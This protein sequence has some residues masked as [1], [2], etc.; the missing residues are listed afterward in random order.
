MTVRGRHDMRDFDMGLAMG[1]KEQRRLCIRKVGKGF[2]ARLGWLNPFQEGVAVAVCFMAA[3]NTEKLP[4]VLTI[5]PNSWREKLQWRH[6][7][8]R[9]C[10]TY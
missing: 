4:D 5:D 7:T 10:Q 3:P 9:S 1:K 8:K 2:E 6:P